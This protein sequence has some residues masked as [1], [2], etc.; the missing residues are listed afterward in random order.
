MSKTNEAISDFN[1]TKRINNAA[2]NFSVNFATPQSPSEF[3]TGETFELIIDDP[4]LTD[5][6]VAFSGI[7]ETVDRSSTDNNKIYSLSGRD[8]GRLLVKQPFKWNCTEAGTDTYSV[9]DLLAEILE[10]TGLTIGRG[11]EQLDYNIKLNTS[12]ESL[13]RFC[14]EWSTKDEALNQLFNQYRKLSGGERFRWY[15]DN[16]GN[17]R[18]LEIN[19]ERAGKL[20]IFNDDQRI[21]DFTVNKDATNIIN[22]FTGVYGED[23]SQG[24]VTRTANESIAVYGLCPSQDVINEP[25]MTLSQMQDKLDSELDQKAVPIHTATVTM[26]GFYDIN[27]GQQIMFPN[28]S[29]YYAL[30]FTV[31]DWAL[32]GTPADPVTTLGLTTDESVISIPNEF[33]IIQ[34]MIKKETD[35]IRSKVGTV[36][37]VSGNR[38][39]VD[40]ESGKGT[41]N[42]RY[43]GGWRS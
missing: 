36:N 18:W 2:I 30:T 15:I 26:S 11:Q 3:D 22:S 40:L 7:I 9:E 32:S 1:V 8:M 35:P 34:A 21:T 14:G 37:W 33:E 42:A 38:T 20:F 12:S 25:Y 41:I 31:V 43:V 29:Y 24:T 23:E 19:K 39:G 27:P 10:D 5:E 13:E 28:D 4:T 17:F 16:A 6:F